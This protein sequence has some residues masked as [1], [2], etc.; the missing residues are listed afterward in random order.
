MR[1]WGRSARTAYGAGLLVL[2]CPAALSAAPCDQ[3]DP[4][5]PSRSA[6][7]T[8]NPSDFVDESR[9][10]MRSF[11]ATGSLGNVEAEILSSTPRGIVRSFAAIPRVSRTDPRS[12]EQ[13]KGIAVAVSLGSGAEPATV[14]LSLRQVCARYFRNTFLY[15]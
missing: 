8:L 1:C 10:E 13:L 9:E 3:Y 15:Y 5:A 12:G 7:I 11:I 2:C 4:S 14:T 6:R